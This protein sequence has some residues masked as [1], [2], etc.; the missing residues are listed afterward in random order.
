MARKY[1][2]KASE[3]VERAL[4]EMKRGK[5]KSGRS[6]KK[7]TSRKQAIAIALSQARRAGGKVPPAPRHAAMN[8]D[9]RV[10]AYLGT[11]R[12]G[13]EIDARGMARAL[14]G[15]DPLE[16]D[17]ALERAEKAGF[18]V[19]SDGRW[20]GPAKRRAHAKMLSSPVVS[21][22]P[23]TMPT[24]E[25]AEIHIHHGKGGYAGVLVLSN[26]KELPMSLGVPEPTNATEAMRGAKRFLMKVFGR[27][28]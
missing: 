8:L 16:A 14:G 19:T 18:A 2:K 5:L 20:F 3:K 7:V 17:Y 6:G 21:A 24:G 25:T 10:R 11:M 4:H 23:V 13:Q 22:A 9:A 15:V 1:G 27:S 28:N 26:G 12:P